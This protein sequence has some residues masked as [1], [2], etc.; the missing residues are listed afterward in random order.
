M[1]QF[2]MLYD[3]EKGWIKDNPPVEHMALLNHE[4]KILLTR[5]GNAD[6]IVFKRWELRQFKGNI[7]TH[8]HPS[9]TKEEE[10]NIKSTTPKLDLYLLRRNSNNL[11]VPDMMFALANEVKEIRAV[12]VDHLYRLINN[13]N[14][15][16]I[17]PILQMIDFIL[18][19]ESWASNELDGWWPWL[20]ELNLDYEKIPLDNIK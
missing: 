1:G 4:G 13:N 19:T 3:V 20:S 15:P 11:S 6:I 5:E 12:S 18:S 14:K 2:A 16:F 17:K 9:R 8:F 10:S 7:L